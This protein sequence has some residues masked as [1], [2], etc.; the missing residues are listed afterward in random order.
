MKACVVVGGGISGLTAAI[1]LK[2][3][4]DS[5][6]LI[7][8]GDQL[9]GLL[10][11]VS[12]ELGNSYDQGTHIPEK[13]GVAEIDEILFDEQDLSDNWHAL[14][15]LVTGNYF[16]GSWDN[17]TQTIDARKLPAALYQQGVG[18]FMQ[19]VDTPDSSNIEAYLKSTLGTT[20][21]Q[22]L[23]EPIIKKL[24][25]S[26]V[27]CA[28]LA[29]RTG[30]NYF[31]AGRIK[32]FDK[33]TTQVLKTHPSFDSKLGFHSAAEYEALLADQGVLL[34]EYYYPKGERG[35]EV[36]ID[37]LA[38]KAQTA[39]VEIFT[40]QQVVKIN[41]KSG[42]ITSVLLSG[43][44]ELDCQLVYWSAP[45]IFALKAALLDAETAPI[46]FR[47]AN[48]LHYT[49]DI[50]PNNDIA[51]YLWNWDACSPIFRITLYHNIRKNQQYQLTAEILSS[52][53]EAQD[54][55]LEQGLKDLK[56]MGLIEENAQVLSSLKQ[57]IHN[58]F[59]VPTHDFAK[60]T[61]AHYQQLTQHFDNFI[62]S[63]RF[64]G[65]CWLQND[66]LKLAYQ[67]INEFLAN[68]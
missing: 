10:S 38:A 37:K 48:L 16:A 43:G 17:T 58:T 59:P 3:H 65:R 44:Q 15:P 33:A 34:P 5:V 47:T 63:G 24:Y 23:A 54:I 46:S 39:G 2:K 27:D 42:A 67:E 56:A 40:S 7:E 4:F 22:H 18:E 1:L 53:E 36:W 9:G 31:G 50:K 25:G 45:P 12:D 35:A 49:F 64:S 41:S 19:L 30:V 21:Y 62:L 32:A 57:T 28:S 52:K 66:V 8:Q 20:F 55:S 51:H 11:S 6:Y 61:D 14:S 68:A 13:T 60:L 29:L 26:E